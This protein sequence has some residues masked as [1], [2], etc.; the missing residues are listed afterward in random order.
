VASIINTIVTKSTT[1]GFQQTGQQ[2]D[3]LSKKQTRLANQSTNTGRAFASQASGLGGFVA[4]YAGAAATFFAL[5]QSFSALS[6]AARSQA[7]VEGVN[8][9]AQSVGQNGPKIVASLKSITQGQLSIAESAQNAGIALSAGLGGEQIDQL[10]DIATRASKVLGRDLTDSIQ[11]LV[12]GVGKLEPELLDELGIF[13]RIEPAVERYA[14]KVGKSVS[15]LTNFER[16]QAFANAVI[17]EG[18]AKYRN[19]DTTLADSSQNLNKLAASLTD[20]TTKIGQV[21]SNILDPIVSYLNK[22]VNNLAGVL[23]VLGTLVFSKLGQVVSQGLGSFKQGI[24]DFAARST[25]RFAQMNNS[26]KEY[27]KQLGIVQQAV[28]NMN[29]ASGM[30]SYVGPR[31]QTKE[32]RQVLASLRAGEEIAPS[33]VASYRKIL[34]DQIAREQARGTQIATSRADELKN[35]TAGLGAA[36]AAVSP[37]V[38][39][40]GSA[41]NL[42]SVAFSKAVDIGGSF[43]R[44]IGRLSI[45][46]GVLDIISTLFSVIT[47][48]ENYLNKALVSLVT[49][50]GEAFDRLTKIRQVNE[51][52]NASFTRGSDE[53]KKAATSLD[54]Y[55]ESLKISKV[56]FE[57]AISSRNNLSSLGIAMQDRSRD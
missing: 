32:V 51:A 20:L 17:E 31:D 49:Y 16:R 54:Q 2:V 14:A 43:L 13:T 47:G 4:A 37:N 40:L 48:G 53:I 45:V 46:Y 11:R 24:D 34:Q 30:A 39:K 25:T 1:Q 35:I 23:V 56:A 52:F 9:L 57:K 12:R 19:V 26:A 5:Q 3:E 7:L 18:T 50:L 55:N 33:Q 6:A 21:L 41:I 44:L 22:D 28:L 42:V 15:S 27:S 36:S 29:K 8:S 10:S 38:N